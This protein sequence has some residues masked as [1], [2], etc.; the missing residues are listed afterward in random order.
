MWRTC[1]DVEF[2]CDVVI[3]PLSLCAY[4]HLRSPEYWQTCG[5]GE[6]RVDNPTFVRMASIYTESDVDS[7]SSLTVLIYQARQCLETRVQYNFSGQLN[8][9]GF[10]QL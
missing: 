7:F 6:L 3:G 9:T 4:V 10:K 5:V 1:S 8:L 2:V